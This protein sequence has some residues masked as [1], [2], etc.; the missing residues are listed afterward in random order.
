MQEAELAQV[1]KVAE[2][3]HMHATIL[4][5][6]YAAVMNM[7]NVKK[8]TCTSG[9]FD[10]QARVMNTDEAIL[11]LQREDADHV[12]EE[13]RLEALSVGHQQRL[14]LQILNEPRLL[15]FQAATDIVIKQGK[16]I[17]TAEKNAVKAAVKAVKD[18]KA[19]ALKEATASCKLEEKQARNF[20]KAK[21]LEIGKAEKAAK[22]LDKAETS[23]RKKQEKADEVA[24][25]KELKKLETLRLKRAMVSKAYETKVVAAE[26]EMLASERHMSLEPAGR[27]WK[28]QKVSNTMIKDD[29]ENA[30]SST[31]NSGFL[32]QLGDDQ[33]AEGGSS[34]LIDG[35]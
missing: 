29:K 9:T 27:E 13:A 20:E 17:I 1:R 24:C 18:A 3:A 8:N 35:A 28:R 12:A 5:Q 30:T 2:D 21:K 10:I 7:R 11:I 4:G 6:Q 19:V 26:T 14:E 25:M 23:S 33:N 22:A 34:I 15:W 32:Q 16:A 31:P